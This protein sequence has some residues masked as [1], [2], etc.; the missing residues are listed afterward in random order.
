MLAHNITPSLVTPGKLRV[1]HLIHTMAYG[2][3]ETAVLNWIRALDKERFDVHLVC[4]ANPGQTE[5]PFV[6]A[7]TRLGLE[8]SYLPWHRGKPVLRAAR[9]LQQLAQAWKTDIVHSHNCYADVVT[10]VASRIGPQRFRT[11]TTTYVWFDYRNWKRNLIQWINA[12]A[13]RHFDRVTAHCENTRLE[14][15][16]RGFK[17]HEVSTLICGFETH[18]VELEPAVRA[19]R[20]AEQGVHEAE[21]VLIN[22]ARF[23]PEKAQVFLLECF[24]QLLQ[25]RRQLKLWLVGVGPLEDE[26]RATAARLQLGETVRF[27]GFVSDLPPLLALADVQVHPAHIEGVPL[28]ICE[29]MAAGLPIVASQVG[30]LPE[31]LDQ[32]RNGLLVS[33]L[34]HARFCAA[35]LSLVDDPVLAQRLGNRARSFIENEYSL[36]TAIGR[37]EATYRELVP[38]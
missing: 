25:Q 6:E 29:G 24:A 35:V 4:F 9:G 27:F 16:K 34:D 8:V 2:G 3:V 36:R 7:A 20:R 33:G 26:L 5:A 11:I 28:A 10:L 23:Y 15:L 31:I 1:V 30:G 21:T 32:G 19:H 37:V 38:C 13:I 14:T 17:P 18:R 12:L 22:V